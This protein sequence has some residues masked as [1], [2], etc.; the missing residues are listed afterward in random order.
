ME[1]GLLNIDRSTVQNA[2]FWK[3][4]QGSSSTLSQWPQPGRKANS[5]L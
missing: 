3:G 1:N 5:G 2:T 4:V